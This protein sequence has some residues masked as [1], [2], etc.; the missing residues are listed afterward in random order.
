[1]YVYF[2]FF[3]KLCVR[4]WTG[5]SSNAVFAT[6]SYSFSSPSFCYQKDKRTKPENL[7]INSASKIGK[8]K[9]GKVY[10]ITYHQG[11]DG[12][13]MYSSTLSLISALCGSVWSMPRPGD[14]AP[15]NNTVPTVQEAVWASGPVWTGAENLAPTGIRFPDR[16]PVVSLCT[17]CGIAETLELMVL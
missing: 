13:Y 3:L 1:M 4:T 12:E 14:F 15:G 5:C 8:L 17:N 9:K 2:H 7:K 10:P 6:A 16:S 11:P